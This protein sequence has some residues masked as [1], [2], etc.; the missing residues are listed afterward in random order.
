MQQKSEHFNNS[1][2][3]VGTTF[4]Y[5]KGDL[6]MELPINNISINISKPKFFLACVLTGGA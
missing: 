3:G 1:Y 6:C 2:I 4:F 5:G